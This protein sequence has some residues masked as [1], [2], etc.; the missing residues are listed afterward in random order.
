M[1][2]KL[3]KVLAFIG[4]MTV[5]DNAVRVRYEVDCVTNEVTSDMEVTVLG[6][7]VTKIPK[8]SAFAEC[9]TIGRNFLNKH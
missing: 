3:T 1:K 5:F 6:C 2:K 8:D 4:A 7:T 9:V